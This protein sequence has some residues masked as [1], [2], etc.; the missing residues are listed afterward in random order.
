MSN[1]N[2]SSDQRE[3]T[4]PSRVDIVAASKA[5]LPEK[6]R[7]VYEKEDI[8]SSIVEQQKKLR[9]SHS[10]RKYLFPGYYTLMNLPHGLIFTLKPG[11]P[12]RPFDFL[13]E[14]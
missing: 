12:I 8:D 4:P 2:R 14:R 3:C 11:R 10:L 1:E 5:L 13:R 6:S 7:A 9:F